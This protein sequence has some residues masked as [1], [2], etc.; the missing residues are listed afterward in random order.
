[1]ARIDHH[2]HTNRYSPDSIIDPHDLLLQA[3]AAGLDGVVITEHD[4]LWPE[5]ELV[6]LAELGRP[7]GVAVM[8]GVEISSLEGDV[9]VYGLK[10]LK[11]VGHCVD[12]RRVLDVAREQGAV[13]V[14]AHPFRF[15]QDFWRIIRD[16][17]QAFDALELASNNITPELRGRIQEVLNGSPMGATASSD[18]HSPEVVGC[19]YSEFP[20][21]I[22]TINEFIVALKN[23]QARPRHHPGRRNV[24]GRF[25]K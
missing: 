1:M 19:Y 15:G 3:H 16:F 9:L 24:S 5:H 8:G 6:E 25:G 4:R 12:L 13:V 23:R 2:L 20:G 14:A 10:S 21:S 18:A 11:D 7:L 17:G 22:T